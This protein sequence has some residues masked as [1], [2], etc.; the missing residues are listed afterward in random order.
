MHV[1][2]VHERCQNYYG[3]SQCSQED[4]LFP[5]KV[6]SINQC[7]MIGLRHRMRHYNLVNRIITKGID[8]FVQDTQQ[9]PVRLPGNHHAA[10]LLH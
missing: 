8:G 9:F 5:V 1:P 3:G 6:H 2:A 10:F 4:N 7:I